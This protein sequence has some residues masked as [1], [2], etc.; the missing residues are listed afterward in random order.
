MRRD[1]RQD[2]QP[3]RHLRPGPTVDREAV[4]GLARAEQ[5]GH[6]AVER[7]GVL[8]ERVEGADRQRRRGPAAQD[9]VHGQG[10]HGHVRVHARGHHFQLDGRGDIRG[11]YQKFYDEVCNNQTVRNN[12]RGR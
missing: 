10:L 6:D 8:P 3:D 9:D 7:V 5:D 1:E 2:L 4:H 11:F 12:W